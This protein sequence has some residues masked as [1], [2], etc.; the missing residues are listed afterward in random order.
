M[1]FSV[2][3]PIYNGEKYLEY[4]LDSIKNQS[5]N[6][7]EVILINDG[8]TDCSAIICEKYVHIDSRF[9][10]I[11]KPNG[12]LINSRKKGSEIAKGE[13]IVCVDCDDAITE[14]LLEIMND[15]I[16]KNTPDI[17]CYG[18]KTFTDECEGKISVPQFNEGLYKTD[19]KKELLKYILFDTDQEKFNYGR[20]LY[21]V[22]LK[23]VKRSIF[24]KNIENIP[25]DITIGEDTVFTMKTMLS[26]NSIYISKIPGY[27]YRTNEDSMMHVLKPGAFNNLNRVVEQ[28][29]IE[30]SGNQENQ[31]VGYYVTRLW[32]T[33]L[34]YAKSCKTYS[35]F[36]Q[37]MNREYVSAGY[38]YNN[39]NIN[40]NK[41]SKVRVW[42]ILHRYWLIAYIISKR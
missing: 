16:E 29:K 40:I 41:A 37:L 38:N 22:P 31:I 17:I 32:A 18:L 6:D 20:L 21:G 10:V 24:T 28:L 4:C 7:Y 23:I 3:V 15:I 30:F 8:S 36:K 5:F 35:E 1:R 42:S 27:Y 25:E 39:I 26:A 19:L 9:K 14:N 33:S 34:S 11:H 2:I 12:G 13:Y